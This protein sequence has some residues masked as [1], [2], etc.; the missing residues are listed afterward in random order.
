MNV[1]RATEGG[2]DLGGL[3]CGAEMFGGQCR[4]M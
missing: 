1:K 2:A 4:D 3:E